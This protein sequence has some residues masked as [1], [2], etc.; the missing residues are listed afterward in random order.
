MAQHIVVDPI[1]RIEGHLRI[2]AVLDDNNVITD[3]YSA[4]TMFRGIEIILK[5]RDPRDAGLLAQR[6]CG[7]CTG[8]HYWTSVRAV[9]NAFGVTIPKNARLVRNLIAGSQFIHD[10]PVHFY[11][12][13]A[14]DWVDLVSALSADPVKAVDVAHR[15]TDTPWNASATNYKAVQDKLKGFAQ[16]SLGIFGNAYWGNP[17][18]KLTPEENLVAVSHY[19]DALTAQRAPAKMMA[20]FGGKNPHPQSIVVGGVTSVQD[21]ENPERI[22]QFR[23][24]LDQH[25]EFIKGA[26]LPDL[27]MAGLA[28]APE[29]AA[30]IGG[31]LKSY[32]SYGFFEQDDTPL[33]G[34]KTLFPSG[35]VLNGDISQVITFDQRK[36]AE[37]VTHSWYRGNAVLHPYQGVTEPNYTGLDKRSD[38]IAYLKTSEKYSWL[39]SPTYDDHRV[40]VGPL[41][42]L[43]VGYARGD[44]NIK[45]QVDR[46]LKVTGLPI[47]VL[48]STVGRTAARCIET[49]IIAEAMSGWLDELERNTASGDLNTWTAFDFD[50]VS[51]NAEG[52]GLSEAPR[53]ALG[54][55]VRVQNGKIDNYQIVVPT[56]WNASPRDGK[57]RVGAYESALVGVKLAKPDEPLEVLRTVH[58]FDPCLACAVHLVDARGRDLG[59]HQISPE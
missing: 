25:V 12:L 40:E 11:H 52:Y 55:W 41:A 10:H 5:G 4:G 24:L 48:F 39:K 30:G 35:I 28:Y 22:S 53:G 29:A 47:G 33:Y 26:Y 46:V 8:V 18:Y 3:A 17:G 9:E 13:H 43:I 15:W 14:L 6:I 58:S 2:E 21:V 7:V 1:S 37:D 31:G 45:D 44:Q 23:S 54:H 27:L 56:T 59:T 49:L 32:L 42:R 19:L 51:K 16:Q 57:N 34:A 50:K 36:V 38:G 20:I